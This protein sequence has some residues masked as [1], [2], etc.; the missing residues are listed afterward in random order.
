MSTKVSENL[1]KE[2]VD[3]LHRNKKKPKVVVGGDNSTTSNEVKESIN[4][5][6]K[7]VLEMDQPLNIGVVKE[8]EVNNMP[9]Y[10]QAC[11][12]INGTRERKKQH[13]SQAT[14]ID[15]DGDD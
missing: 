3:S 15:L 8:K 6:G 7:R 10:L 5:N 12:G 13:I 2:E 11:F 9:S 4:T 14:R 1:T